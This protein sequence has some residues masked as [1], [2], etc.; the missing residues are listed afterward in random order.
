M[1]VSVQACQCVYGQ[2][3]DHEA[4]ETAHTTDN[5]SEQLPRSKTEKGKQEGGA[6]K[7][8]TSCVNV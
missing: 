4:Q 8:G 3:C 6:E 2:A 7:N 1:H 5:Y